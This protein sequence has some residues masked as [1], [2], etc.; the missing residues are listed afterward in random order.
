[1]MVLRVRKFVHIWLLRASVRRS[2]R[3]EDECGEPT[4]VFVADSAGHA[5]AYGWDQGGERAVRTCDQ[6][7]GVGRESRFST[8]RASA[9]AV[10][11]GRSSGAVGVR[12]GVSVVRPGCC[13]PAGFD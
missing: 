1:M 13:H 8:A 5:G 12:R 4:C 6:E 11:D 2:V 7:G 3:A 9:R 10:L